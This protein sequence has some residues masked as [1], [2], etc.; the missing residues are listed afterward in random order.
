MKWDYANAAEGME[1][2]DWWLNPH[3][4]GIQAE[5]D[6]QFTKQTSK[7]IHYHSYGRHVA[8]GK[9]PQLD[10][11]VENIFNDHIPFVLFDDCDRSQLRCLPYIKGHKMR[12]AIDLVYNAL[13]EK[14]IHLYPSVEAFQNHLYFYYNPCNYLGFTVQGWN[15]I[16]ISETELLEEHKCLICE[17]DDRIELLVHE[18]THLCYKIYWHTPLFYKR[19]TLLKKM[20]VAYLKQNASEIRIAINYYSLVCRYCHTKKLLYILNSDVISLPK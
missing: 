4:I 6:R 12:Y 5:Y 17:I 9:P 20:I 3:V 7:A 16:V 8:H 10:F 19:Y 15:L 1:I 13:K 2:Q 11:N 18:V 14:L